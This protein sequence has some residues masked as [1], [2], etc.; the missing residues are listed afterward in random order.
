MRPALRLSALSHIPSIWIFTHDSV[1]VGEDGPTHQPVEH[2]AA[3]RAIPNF[4]LLRPGDANEVSE[5]WKFALQNRQGPTALI[6]SRQNVPTLDRK[7]YAAADGTARGGYVLADLGQD[8]P[9]MILLATGSELGLAAAA[10]EKLAENGRNIRLVSL[11]SWELFRQQDQDYQEQ[12][13]PSGIRARLAVEA[14]VDQGWREWVGDGGAVMGIN[15][16]GA[17]APGDQIFQELGFTVDEVVR[18]AEQV[19]EGT[20]G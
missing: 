18:Q 6:L 13:L 17:S 4:I 1:G 5:A 2:L 16:Y 10:A 9:D 3:L 14:G 19:M 12:V 7:K 8:D 15:R 11:P 20:Q